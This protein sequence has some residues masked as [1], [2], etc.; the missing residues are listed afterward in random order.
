[1][2]RRDNQE[3]FRFLRFRGKKIPFVVVDVV[4]VDRISRG[5][6]NSR[7]QP[8]QRLVAPL[9]G[10]SQKIRLNARDTIFL[11][12]GGPWFTFTWKRFDPFP[13]RHFAETI[14]NELLDKFF[15]PERENEQNKLRN[16][17]PRDW[18]RTTDVWFFSIL[19]WCRF[20]VETSMGSGSKARELM[21][22][23]RWI[24][25]RR[26]CWQCTAELEKRF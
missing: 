22:G 5:F 11:R 10:F 9:G 17:E 6:G 16:E 26:R 2:P 20:W 7:Q 21:S 18:T 24:S 8:E 4:V 23:K 3:M 12:G 14:K 25:S 19:C 13:S 1:M 15:D